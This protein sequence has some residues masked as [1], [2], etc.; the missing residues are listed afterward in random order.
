[1]ESWTHFLSIKLLQ[2]TFALGKKKIYEVNPVTIKAHY[3]C[4]F[5]PVLQLLSWQLMC[6]ALC[7]FT[8]QYIG[9]M[10]PL[11]ISK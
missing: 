9:Q 8:I 2:H 11:C 6:D 4:L 5:P 7:Y 3:L 1:M 10:M